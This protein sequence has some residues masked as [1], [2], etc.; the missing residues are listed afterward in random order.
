MTSV[1]S[2][3]PSTQAPTR[4]ANSRLVSSLPRSSRSTTRSPSAIR[5][6]SDGRLL[7]PGPGRAGGACR[8]SGTSSTANFTYRE[9]RFAYSSTAGA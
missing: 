8:A 6:S 4:R 2:F 1:T 3:A 7:V 5:S 9:M